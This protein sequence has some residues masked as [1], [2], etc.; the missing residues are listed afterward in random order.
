MPVAMSRSPVSA[1]S[2][3]SALIPAEMLTPPSLMFPSKCFCAQK[4]GKRAF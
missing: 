1:Q 2:E 3:L 4:G